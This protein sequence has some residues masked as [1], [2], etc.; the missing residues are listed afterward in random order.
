L[1]PAL[2]QS[3]AAVAAQ[4]APEEILVTVPLPGLWL[5][6][7]PAARDVRE[8]PPGA[9]EVDLGDDARGERRRGGRWRGG[10]ADT[11]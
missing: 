6:Q 10:R 7:Q 1:P 4:R 5:S 11:A 3:F 2:R 8:D 9:T